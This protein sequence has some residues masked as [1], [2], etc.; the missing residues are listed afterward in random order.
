MLLITPLFATSGCALKIGAQQ[1]PNPRGDGQRRTRVRYEAELISPRFFADHVEATA[2]IG[3]V[4]VSQSNDRI[5]V[6]D[7]DGS[8]NHLPVE[9]QDILDARMGVRVFPF[10]SVLRPELGVIEP[11]FVGGGGF[12]SNAVTQRSPQHESHHGYG[13]F[14]LDEEHD[15]VSDGWFTYLGGGLHLN[16]T[17]NAAV[18]LEARHD[19]NR[20]DQGFDTGGTSVMLGVRWNY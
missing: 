3:Y 11:Y 10:A 13:W 4:P 7:H 18:L 20:D 16:L 8:I 15:T 17:S 14:S 1:M 2:A 5:H 19:F 9:Q 12:Y 6:V